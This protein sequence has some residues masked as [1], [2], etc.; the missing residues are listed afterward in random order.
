MHSY[1]AL[2]GNHP[3]ISTAELAA[4]LPDFQPKGYPRPD[5]LAFETKSDL[6]QA[7][8]NRLGGIIMLAKRVVGDDVKL[9][10][11]P[12]VLAT[13]LQEVKGKAVFAL[14]SIGVP[15]RHAQEMYMTCKKA[16][17]SKGMASRFV[18]NERNHAKAIQL[19]DEELLNPKRGCELVI[20]QGK[21]DLWVGRTVAAQ[22]V[23]AYTK[24]DMEKPVRDTTV[25]LL[26][27]KL[28]Q[29]LLNFGSYLAKGEK[30]PNS[31]VQIPKSPL[32]VFDPFCGTGV[33]PIEA[34]L[35]GDHVLASDLSE[36][37]V[38]GT[39]KNVEWTRKTYAILKKNVDVTVWKQ[40]AVKPFELKERP[41]VIVT[42]GTLGPALKSRPTVKEAETMCRDA[43]ELT[44]AFLKNCKETLPGVPVVLTLPV[45]YAQKRMIWL[46]K[47]WDKLPELG[48]SP[49]LPPHV[50]PTNPGRFSLLYRRADQF[51]GREVVMLKAS[52]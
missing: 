19:H 52:T 36:K 33:I 6:D 42:E 49:V 8:L 48:F 34:M 22:H 5:L 13:E 1:L 46:T 17:K 23:K 12:Q 14:R 47:I 10:D 21:T 29:I 37:A 44:V 41:D 20:L 51:V 39:E 40:N 4:V 25:G 45:W 18:G 24:R 26:P 7:F 3:A 28:A 16:L 9:E 32:T 31:K 35:R 27:P 43:E 15:P 30:S 11:V 2:I 50:E 38:K